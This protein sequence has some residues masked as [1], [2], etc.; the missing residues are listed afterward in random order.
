[1]LNSE[2]EKRKKK[3]KQNT[4]LKTIKQLKASN[5]VLFLKL[6]FHFLWETNVSADGIT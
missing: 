3:N 1:M 2:L 4:T 6:W 5:L